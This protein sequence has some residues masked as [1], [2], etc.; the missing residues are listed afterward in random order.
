VTGAEMNRVKAE[1][2][3][4]VPVVSLEEVNGFSTHNSP[5]TA[6]IKLGRVEQKQF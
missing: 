5:W 2:A 4:W 1:H 6:D 3:A